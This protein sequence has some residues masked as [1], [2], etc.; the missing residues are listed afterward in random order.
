MKDIQLFLMI[1]FH[2]SWENNALW[3]L[4]TDKMADQKIQIKQY[5]DEILALKESDANEIRIDLIFDAK[6]IEKLQYFAKT[7]NLESRITGEWIFPIN[8]LSFHC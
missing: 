8:L 1:F 3:I 7:H 5:R 6:Y 4:T 2:D